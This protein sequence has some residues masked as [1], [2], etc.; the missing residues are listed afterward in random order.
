MSNDDKTPTDEDEVSSDGPDGGPSMGEG[1][2][3][4]SGSEEDWNTS[5]ARPDASHSGAVTGTGNRL[6]SNA[7]REGPLPAIQGRQDQLERL[8]EATP[9]SVTDGR[10]RLAS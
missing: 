10:G 1:G 2:A 4:P 9:P 3:M 8:R 5:M 6:A 7:R